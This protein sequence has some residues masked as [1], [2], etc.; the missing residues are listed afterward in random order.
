M[1]TDKEQ[2][3]LIRLALIEQKQSDLMKAQRH[4][5]CDVREFM[6]K[7]QPVIQMLQRKEASVRGIIIGVTA[8]ISVAFGFIQLI[9][10]FKN[11]IK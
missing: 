10:Y 11:L 4:M 7:V 3:L 9:I 6:D 5:E 8:L 1:N 2:D